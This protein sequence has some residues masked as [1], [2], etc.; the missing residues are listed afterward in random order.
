MCGLDAGSSSFTGRVAIFVAIAAAVAAVGAWKEACIAAI[1]RNVVGSLWTFLFSLSFSDEGIILLPL[2]IAVSV[3]FTAGVWFVVQAHRAGLVKAVLDQITGYRLGKPLLKDAVQGALEDV[4]LLTFAQTALRI[5]W[6]WV[7]AEFAPKWS[8]SAWHPGAFGAAR[9]DDLLA[10]AGS[11][12][13]RAAGLGDIDGIE[14]APYNHGGIGSSTAATVAGGCL[15]AACVLLV[16][17]ID[18]KFFQAQSQAG[19]ELDVQGHADDDDEEERRDDAGGGVDGGAEGEHDHA[20]GPRAAAAGVV[21]SV[22]RFAVGTVSLPYVASACLAFA[23]GFAVLLPVWQWAGLSFAQCF[24]LACSYCVPVA[25]LGYIQIRTLALAKEYI[26]EQRT[27]DSRRVA[28]EA[29]GEDPTA[30]MSV[31]GSIKHTLLW[32]VGW[33]R[34]GHGYDQCSILCGAG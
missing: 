12:S 5:I 26:A 31:A 10:P 20:A 27:L 21:A 29:V 9:E 15:H 11:G 13:M 33:Q 14:D 8:L 25:L 28:T 3:V 18:T 24:V 4:V 2:L 23:Q 32:V 22:F 17:G 6:S 1:L 7:L 30:G 34:G 19:A 16:I